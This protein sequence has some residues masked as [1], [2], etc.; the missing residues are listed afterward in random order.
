MRPVWYPYMTVSMTS[1]LSIQKKILTGTTTANQ[2]RTFS[3]EVWYLP[4]HLPFHEQHHGFYFRTERR[5]F[6][7][8]KH[9]WQTFW[10]CWRSFSLSRTGRQSSLTTYRSSFISVFSWWMFPADAES[11]LMLTHQDRYFFSYQVILYS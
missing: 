6:K 2:R 7:S 11:H 1:N 10:C 9:K 4:F 8:N 5:K 3:I